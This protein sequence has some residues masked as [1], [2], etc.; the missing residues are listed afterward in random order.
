MTI[1]FHNTHFEISSPSLALCPGSSVPEIAFAGRSNSGKST[2]INTLCNHRQLAFASQTPGRT[3]LLNFFEV[4]QHGESIARLVDL[5][6]YGYAQLSANEQAVWNKELGGYLTTRISLRGCVL[7][8]DSRRGL[9]DRDLTF[10]N[11]VSPRKLAVHVLLSKAD[12][13]KTA[14]KKEALILAQQLL[15]PFIENDQ[16]ISLQLWSSTKKLGLTELNEKLTHWIQTQQS[17]ILQP[18]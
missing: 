10:L 2:T 3:Q 16:E 5:P 9:Q 7:I 11:F 14:E 4:R 6:G 8:V 18:I 15:T 13:L 17:N 12:K 1:N